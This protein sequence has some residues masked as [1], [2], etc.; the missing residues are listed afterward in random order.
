MIYV[1]RSH[2][3]LALFNIYTHQNICSEQCDGWVQLD[4]VFRVYDI[5]PEECCCSWSKPSDFLQA[6]AILGN[7]KF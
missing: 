6:V 1:D 2:V 4:G 5:N 7:K 3:K